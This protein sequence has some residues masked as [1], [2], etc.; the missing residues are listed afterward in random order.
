MDA[1]VELYL[2]GVSQDRKS[3]NRLSVQKED[4]KL[5]LTPSEY[6]KD[7]NFT[8]YEE[9][10]FEDEYDGDEDITISKLF[11]SES[12]YT[13]LKYALINNG[14]TLVLG[15]WIMFGSLAVF[16]RYLQEEGHIP[17]EVPS[18]PFDLI[19][20]VFGFAIFNDLS[21][22]TSRYQT[23]AKQFRSLLDSI[24]VFSRS[25]LVSGYK[26]TSSK[27]D[28]A[29][30]GDMIDIWMLLRSFADMT[31]RA[32]VSETNKEIYKSYPDIIIEYALKS[33][34]MNGFDIDPVHVISTHNLI[35]PIN[36][37]K[38]LDRVTGKMVT[39]D[40]T[41]GYA[42]LEQRRFSLFNKIDEFRGRPQLY[43]KD[44]NGNYSQKNKSEIY[45]SYERHHSKH[46][47]EKEN[48]IGVVS[49]FSTL[50]AMRIAALE[51]KG[52]ITVSMMSSLMKNMS[53]IDSN[54]TNLF[55]NTLS[56]SPS[57]LKNHLRASL[58]LWMAIVI[59]RFGEF[60]FVSA[61]VLYLLVVFVYFGM[62]RV[63]RLI[64]NPYTLMDSRFL[65]GIPFKRWI[66]DSRDGVD[67]MFSINHGIL[68]Q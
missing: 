44:Q 39:G 24:D 40:S 28:V 50:I 31:F 43:T 65:L 29:T 13:R 11:P 56:P 6:S 37:K 49:V 14:L 51:R 35:P 21:N 46:K 7:D 9:S 18:A 53:A 60:G 30:V 67:T 2:S 64:E 8:E 25:L 16:L 20:V 36:S 26:K 63:A 19:G 3:L 58:Y 68:K 48:N 55:V 54:T 32:L 17:M 38:I 42:L 4:Y 12:C 1:N 52:A 15:Y 57:V 27:P 61:I 10:D 45:R 62:Y 5:R 34:D 41:K 22:A 47:S 59:L 33:G 66:M 23:S